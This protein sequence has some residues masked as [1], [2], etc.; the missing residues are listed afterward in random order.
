MTLLIIPQNTKLR[1]QR[2]TVRVQLKM[3]VLLFV[4]WTS[5]NV[6]SILPGF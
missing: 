2:Q 5:Y 6:I 4:D 3:S 1:E